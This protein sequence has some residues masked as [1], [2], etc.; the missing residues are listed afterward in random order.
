MYIVQLQLPWIN[1][2]NSHGLASMLL[3]PGDGNLIA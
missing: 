3:G 1:E 2:I